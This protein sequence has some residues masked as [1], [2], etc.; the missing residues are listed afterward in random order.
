VTS[1]SKRRRLPGRPLLVALVLGAGIFAALKLWPHGSA[2]TGGAARATAPVRVTFVTAKTND[3]PV[4]L[5]GLGTVQPYQTVTLRSRV[6]GQVM[7]VGFRQGQMVKEGQVLVQIDPR[8]YQ[9]ALEQAKAKKAQDE[10]TL[11]NAKLDLR[12]YQTLVSREA[13]SRSNWTPSR[14]PWAN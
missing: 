14:R 7:K 6:D 4:Y 8:P 13:G 9:A 12:R 5:N 1:E 11:H 10:A 3:F 2:T